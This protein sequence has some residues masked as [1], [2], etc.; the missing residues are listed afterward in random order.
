MRIRVIIALAVVAALT[1]S[2]A[3]SSAATRPVGK[4]MITLSIPHINGLRPVGAAPGGGMP[5]RL[6]SGPASGQPGDASPAG[7]SAGMTS[8]FCTITPRADRTVVIPTQ[9]TRAL[10]G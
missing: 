10:A 4:G 7:L 3:N 6:C 1:L 2:A 9:G 8:R 5:E